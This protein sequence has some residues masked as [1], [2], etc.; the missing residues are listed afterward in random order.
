MPKARALS[1]CLCLT[2]PTIALFSSSADAVP[3]TL[4]EQRMLPQEGLAIAFASTVL[5]SQLE[6]LIQSELGSK[7][8]CAPLVGKAGSIKLISSKQ[9]NKKELET[10]TDVFFDAQCQSLYIKAKSD[11]TSPKADVINVMQTAD[12]TGPTG[13]KLG[14]LIV[15]ENAVL[16]SND[17][18]VVSGL[19]T[20]TPAGSK[21]R[22]YLGLNC[23]L[24]GLFDKKPPPF[25]CEGGI[26]QNFPKLNEALASV[27]PLT[28]TIKGKEGSKGVEFSGK[29]SDMA[30]GALGALTITAPTFKKL[31]ISGKSKHYGTAVTQGSAATFSLFP[32]KPTSWTIVDKARDATFAIAVKDD[33]TRNSAGTVKQTSTGKVLASFTADQSGTGSITYSDGST[34]TITSWLTS[35]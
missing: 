9:I 31:A 17:I 24:S 27:T 23:D 16:G 19:G 18:K 13:F 20:F 33:K 10:E 7:N 15:N 35:E 1:M 34:A 11:I 5:Q 25:P 22:S 14:E 26:A 6:I 32:P 12:Y 2:A 3:Q 4:V 29:E 8:K 21:R 28:L 30:T